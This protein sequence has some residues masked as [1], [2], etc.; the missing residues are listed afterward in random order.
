ME[1]VCPFMTSHSS[2][3]ASLASHS[4][5][6]SN[7]TAVRIQGEG[8]WERMT[9]SERMVVKELMAI[10]KITTV[11]PLDTLEGLFTPFQV[12]IL[13]NAKYIHPHSSPPKSH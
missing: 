4:V 6:G 2:H 12:Y 7:P 9:H 1:A 5:E 13:Q 8:T 11:G 3:V 10:S